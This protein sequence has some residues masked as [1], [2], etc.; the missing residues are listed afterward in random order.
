MLVSAT[1]TSENVEGIKRLHRTRQEKNMRRGY[2]LITL[3]EE[4]ETLIDLR[5]GI[6][7]SGTP[8]A[9]VWIYG[10]GFSNGSGTATGGN[11]DLHGKAVWESF[12]SAGWKIDPHISGEHMIRDAILAVGQELTDDPLYLVEVHP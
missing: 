4:P 7:S 12:H 3:T 9:C 10:D 6:T 1:R 8:Y 5:I 11:Y 2:K